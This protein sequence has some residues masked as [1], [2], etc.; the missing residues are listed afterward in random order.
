M[1]RKLID[2]SIYLENDVASDPPGLEP[3]IEYHKHADTYEQ[4]APCCLGLAQGD[5]PDGEGG[6]V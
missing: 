3:H 5:V 6:A 2:L 1:P 4:I